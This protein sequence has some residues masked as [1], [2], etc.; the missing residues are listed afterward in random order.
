MFSIRVATALTMAAM[1]AGCGGG[2]GTSVPV[3]TATP[4]PSPVPSVTTLAVGTSP[5]AQTLPSLNGTTGT[6]TLTG[7]AGTP[8]NA[9]VTVA[10]TTAPPAGIAALASTARSARA[11]TRTPIAYFTFT[12]NVDIQLA[13]FP[14]FTIAFPAGLVPAGT[15]IHEAF[16]DASTSQP[17]YT[18]DIAFGPNGATFSSSAAAPKLLAG[19]SYVFA[20]YYELD[21]N[22]TSAP[23]TTP[24][25][26]P[27]ATP[28]PTASPTA[29]PTSSPSPSPTPAAGFLASVTNVTSTPFS[30]GSSNTGVQTVAVGSDGKVYFADAGANAV[31]R[32]DPALGLVTYPQQYNDNGFLNNVSPTSVAK[33]RDGRMWFTTRQN[34]V[35]AFSTDAFATVFKRANQPAL[36]AITSGVD[37]RLWAIGNTA[38]AAFTTDGGESDYPLPAI[39]ASSGRQACNAITPGPDGALWYTCYPNIVGRVTTGGQITEYTT[40]ADRQPYGIMAGSDGNVWFEENANN[41]NNA[42]IG[43]ITPQGAITE[44][45]VA[46]AGLTGPMCAIAATPDGKIWIGNNSQ[47]FRLTVTGAGTGTF[48]HV[49]FPIQQPP[50]NTIFSSWVVGPDQQTLWASNFGRGALVI[51]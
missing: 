38:I 24:S 10:V 50:L 41:A 25:T 43:R 37:G 34:Y 46:S 36:N 6:V 40:S 12:P 15:A 4:T 51:H 39:T 11:V 2:G 22:A 21:A 33:G 32:I 28:V 14:T 8:A 27:T 9:S 13:S 20:F 45:N 23:T 49:Q 17:L 48:Q 5:A 26:V 47:A 7:A 19:K 31:Q 29:T 3:L 30:S 35:F 16:L 18:L 1:L 44:I 42:S